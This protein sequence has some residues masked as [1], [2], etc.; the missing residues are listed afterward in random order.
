MENKRNRGYINY[1]IAG[2]IL[3]IDV[4]NKTMTV[5]A[6]YNGKIFSVR[7]HISPHAVFKKG[8]Q[9][10]KFEDFIVG[11]RVVVKFQISSKGDIIEAIEEI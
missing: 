5:E 9:M 4:V 10:S 8:N 7:G 1:K 3:D 6:E 11:D 2:K